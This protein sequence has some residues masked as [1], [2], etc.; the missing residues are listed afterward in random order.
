MRLCL[1]PVL[2]ALLDPVGLGLRIV[3][4][5]IRFGLGSRTTALVTGGRSVAKLSR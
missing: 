1:L 5:C 3:R 4:A 2:N